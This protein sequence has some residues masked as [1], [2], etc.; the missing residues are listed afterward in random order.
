M[1]KTNRHLSLLTGLLVAFLA[2][3]AFW[4]SFGTLRDLAVQQGISPDVAWL[5]PA[6]IDGAIIVFSLSVVQVSLAGERPRYPWVLVGVFTALS[7]MLNMLHAAATILPKLMAA[8][9][10]VALFLSFELLMNQIKWAARRQSLGQ[11]V[12]ELETAIAI[13]QAERSQLEG[14]IA[15]ATTA[16]KTKNEA[17]RAVG[18]RLNQREG[19]TTKREPPGSLPAKS[20]G[21]AGETPETDKTKARRGRVFR[22]TVNDQRTEAK[23]ESQA[24]LLAYLLTHPQANHRDMA[25]VMGRARSTI[26]RYIQKLQAQGLLAWGPDGWQVIQPRPASEEIPNTTEDKE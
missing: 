11:T 15:A 14:E 19:A 1:T 23:D 22:T 7:V 2:A 4:L 6:I 21:Q 3:A 18:L 26:Q 24:Q 17:L 25:E 20:N 13:L 5:Y 10:P 9:P 12:A 8:I 16:L